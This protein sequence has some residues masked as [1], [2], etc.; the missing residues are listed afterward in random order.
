MT[1]RLEYLRGSFGTSDNVVSFAYNLRL[2]RLVSALGQ[3]MP[4]PAR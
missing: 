2:G 1:D 3:A 4:R